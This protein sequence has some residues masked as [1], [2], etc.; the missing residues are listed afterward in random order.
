MYEWM[1]ELINECFKLINDRMHIIP[2]RQET[3]DVRTKYHYFQARALGMGNWEWC[4]G[5]E[6]PYEHPPSR[7]WPCLVENIQLFL[8]QRGAQ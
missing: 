4:E 6:G 7:G 3:H 8:K 1:N 5:G 2:L